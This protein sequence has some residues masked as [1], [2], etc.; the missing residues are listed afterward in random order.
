MI[1]LIKNPQKLIAIN[2]GYK[3]I[4]S[5][6]NKIII[7]HDN[8]KYTCKICGRLQKD[9]YIDKDNLLIS[10]KSNITYSYFN[11]HSPFL[12]SYCY[13][14]QSNYIKRLQKPPLNDIAD[15]ILFKDKY[16]PQNFRTSSDNND[17]FFILKDPPKPPY[18]IMIKEYIISTSFVNM[19]HRVKATIDNNLIIINYGLRNYFVNPNILFNAL[20]EYGSQ[21]F[22]TKY[23]LDIRFVAKLIHKTYIKQEKELH[24]NI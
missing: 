1:K 8:T 6:P 24:G 11:P 5:V 19:S 18:I 12:C 15:I 4:K 16:I 7:S 13:F 20:K 10:R 9:G 2:F 21:S 17:L 22:K 3:F 14:I 23:T